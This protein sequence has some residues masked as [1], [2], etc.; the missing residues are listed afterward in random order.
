MTWDDGDDTPANKSIPLDEL[1][2][3]ADEDEGSDIGSDMGAET[4][5]SFGARPRLQRNKT[6]QVW[7]AKAGYHPIVA[8]EA[9]KSSEGK[10]PVFRDD[11]NFVVRDDDAD[12]LK[13][14]DQF[15]DDRRGN[16]DTMVASMTNSAICLAKRTLRTKQQTKLCAVTAT[17]TTTHCTQQ[18]P[19]TTTTSP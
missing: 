4:T 19:L 2:M 18:Q 9:V 12:A 6:G 3:V 11:P 10:Q 1:V 14:D 17:S 5:V 13:P 16:L 7:C 8:A 15:W